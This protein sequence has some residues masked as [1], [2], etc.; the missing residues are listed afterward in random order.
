ME[1]PKFIYSKNDNNGGLGSPI[2]HDNIDDNG[3]NFLT[4]LE[5]MMAAVKEESGQIDF[6]RQKVRDQEFLRQEMSAR[7]IDLE[8]R[9]A[10][11]KAELAKVILKDRK[12]FELKLLLS[13]LQCQLSSRLTSSKTCIRRRKLLVKRLKQKILTIRKRY[14]ICNELLMNLA[15]RPKLIRR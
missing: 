15:Y 13:Q 2:S 14:L 1:S 6:L 4:Q 3:P 8:S 7:L 5:Y 10:S 9:E 11:L 12:L